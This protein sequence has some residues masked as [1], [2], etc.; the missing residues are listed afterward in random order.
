MKRLI[1]VVGILALAAPAFADPAEEPKPREEQSAL[2]AAELEM[3]EA[4]LD[5][6]V[7]AG[8]KKC[9]SVTN[10]AVNYANVETRGGSEVN[11][12]QIALAGSLVFFGFPT[13]AQ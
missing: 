10:V 3:T 2:V 7:A 9:C 13:N 12:T 5:G 8:N 4:E 11:I 1:A 6:V